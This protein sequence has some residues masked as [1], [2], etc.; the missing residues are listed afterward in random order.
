MRAFFIQQNPLL[1]LFF[2]YGKAITVPLRRL[3]AVSKEDVDRVLYDAECALI[4]REENIGGLEKALQKVVDT[5]E[6]WMGMDIAVAQAK[7]ARF[8]NAI[9]QISLVKRDIISLKDEI[10][11]LCKYR[12]ARPQ[13]IAE[14]Q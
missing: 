8:K 4:S 5:P 10:A 9:H 7:Q 14:R 3:F 13:A 11:D 12:H 6:V 1:G 2:W